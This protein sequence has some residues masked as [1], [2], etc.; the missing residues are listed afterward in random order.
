MVTCIFGELVKGKVVEKAA[1]VKMAR[2]E[3]VRFMAEKKIKDVEELKGFH[4]L[5]YKFSKD[6]SDSDTYTFIQDSSIEKEDF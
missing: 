3:M 6:L 4:Y 1:R 2:G 5:N